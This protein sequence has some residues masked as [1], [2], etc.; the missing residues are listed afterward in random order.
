MRRLPTLRKCVVL[1]AAITLFAMLP[2]AGYA[3]DGAPAK[4]GAPALDSRLYRAQQVLLQ[5][6]GPAALAHVEGLGLDVDAGKVVVEVY[7]SGDVTAAVAAI[8]AAGGVVSYPGGELALV[9]AEVPLGSLVALSE[10]AAVRWVQPPAQP[11]AEAVTGEGV[12]FT[13]ADDWHAAGITGGGV[14]VAVMDLGFTGYASAQASGDLPASLITQSYCGGGIGGTTSHGTAVAEI[15]HDMAPDAQIYL[16]CVDQMTDISPA[17]D[18]MNA[19][20]IDVINHSVGWF[21]TERGDG[22]GPFLTLSNKAEGYGIAWFNS[23]GNYALRHWSGNFNDS[24]DGDG[25][26]E[27][28]GTDE[29]NTFTLEGHQQVYV[30]LK[31]DEWPTSSNDFDLY[32]LDITGGG[33]EVDWSVDTQD[34]TQPPTEVISYTN[35]TGS[36]RTYAVEIR[37][38]SAASTPDMDLFVLSPDDLEYAVTSRSLNDNSTVP[39]IYAS[40]AVWWFN[41]AIEDF[42]SRGPTIDARTKP[43]LTGPDGVNTFTYGAFG[44]SSAASPHAAGAAALLLSVYPWMTPAEL[45]AAVLAHTHDAGV[46]GPDNL[47]GVGVLDLGTPPTEACMGA[48]ATIVGTAGD[49][50]LT[51]TS[52]RDVI[53]GLEGDDEIDGLGGNDVICGGDGNDSIS[54]GKGNDYIYGEKGYDVILGNQGT[55][56]IN[57]GKGNDVVR[58]GLGRDRIKGGAGDDEITGNTGRDTIRGG[59]GND[60]ITGDA[61]DDKLYGNDHHDEIYGGTGNDVIYGGSGNDTL[62]GNGGADELYGGSGTDTDN[63]GTANDYCTQAAT[64]VG[65]EV[66]V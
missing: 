56:K 2:A 31:W 20:G 37:E 44:G 19:Q 7:P 10:D 49:D 28:S 11:F 38:F 14:K 33:V 45:R 24:N 15:V 60:Y 52:G 64:Y 32:L 55:D 23:A 53:V 6:G 57:A 27:F 47:Y 54:G 18:Y 63:G 17:L 62:Y 1:L 36:T 50:V 30:A 61:Y 12:A 3:D 41:G 39:N 8:E 34:G 51:G 65:C 58:G 35:P 29:R 16:I 9:G 22:T 48:T 42:S 13:D 46:A 26:H 66:I 4:T 43:D 25:I 40:G 5:Q 21:N 59:L